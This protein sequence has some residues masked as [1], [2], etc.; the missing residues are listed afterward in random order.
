MGHL[1]LVVAGAV[2]VVGFS[3]AIVTVMQHER[4]SCNKHRQKIYIWFSSSNNT[5]VPAVVIPAISVAALETAAIAL[6]ETDSFEAAATVIAVR[7][8]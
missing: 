3:E 6:G 4:H 5:S 7:T 8:H 1:V 2:V